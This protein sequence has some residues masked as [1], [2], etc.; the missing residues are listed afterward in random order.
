MNIF[1]YELRYI[2]MFVQWWS[3][4]ATAQHGSLLKSMIKPGNIIIISNFGVS[5]V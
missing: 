4:L 3:K 1:Y 5:V 2:S